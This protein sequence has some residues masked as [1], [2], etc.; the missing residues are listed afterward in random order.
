MDTQEITR[1]VEALQIR[2]RQ[3]AR[4]DK[5]GD[6]G[7]AAKA[8]VCEFLRIYAGPKSAFLQQAEAA[9]GFPELLGHYTGLHSQLIH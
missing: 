4:H 9:S 5:N 1:Q 2:V 7:E 8:Q 6:H 3:Y